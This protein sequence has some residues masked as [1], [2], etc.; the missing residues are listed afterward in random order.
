MNVTYRTDKNILYIA[1]EGRI[2][3]SNAALAEETIISIKKENE[4]KYLLDLGAAVSLSLCQEGVNVKNIYDEDCC[5][6]HTT[7]FSSWR[8]TGDRKN[9]ILT[10]IMLK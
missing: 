10:Y 2:D 8:R 3:A 1:L 9:Q 6:Y 5:T 7:T 4:D